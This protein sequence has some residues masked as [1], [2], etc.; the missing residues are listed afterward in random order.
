MIVKNKPFQKDIGCKSIRKVNFK[1]YVLS[2]LRVGV[3][4]LAMWLALRNQDWGKTWEIFKGLNLWILA[5]AIGFLII[6]QIITASRW[7]LLLRLQ[8]IDIG[9]GA[10]IKLTFVGFFYNNFLPGSVGGDVLRAWYVTKHTPKRL[11]AVLSVFV[12]RA[13]GLGGLLVMAIIAYLLFPKTGGI[14]KSLAVPDL[15][16]KYWWV[17]VVVAAAIAAGLGIAYLLPK[18]RPLMKLG[19][20]YMVTTGR[21]ISYQDEQIGV[22]V[23]LPAGVDAGLLAITLFCQTL[24]IFG[25]W[26]VGRELGIDGKFCLLSCFYTDFVGCWY[27]A[28]Q[29]WRDRCDGGYAE[30]SFWTGRR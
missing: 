4:A 19:Y 15:L 23:L 17:A 13:I 1:K 8:S 5:I 24:F 3:A 2:F 25:L 29:Y 26:L 28:D 20:T 21:H 18:T 6:N 10:A 9:L 30:I 12:D 7:Y 27:A 16:T 11:E 22:F 14:E